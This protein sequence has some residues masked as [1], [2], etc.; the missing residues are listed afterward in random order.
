MKK[1]Y[2]L[3]LS[4]MVVMLIFFNF[5]FLKK[6]NLISKREKAIIEKFID[7]DTARLK[8]GR[9][10][11]LININ[12]PE[13]K[14]YGYLEAIEFMSQFEKKEVEIEIM[15][16]D[17]YNRLLARI[18]VPEYLNLII[19]EKGLGNKFLVERN[20][21]KIFAKA[22]KE[23]IEKGIGRWNHSENFGCLKIKINQKDEILFLKN[24]CESELKDLI[25]K[26]ESRKKFLIS[27]I[28]SGE[29]KV[30]SKKGIN[31]ETDIFI[32]LKEDIWNNDKDS[33]YI[34]DNKNKIISYYSYGY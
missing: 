23:A 12:T 2:A 18:F 19:V 28:K 17:K 7:G 4:I 10:L 11:R 15:G 20:E 9:I 3:I 5:C 26:D 21:K 8:D 25:I 34:F 33:V 6:I 16:K 31:N 22:E 32:G 14:E 24:I 1:K 29:I 27:E 30:H 13:K